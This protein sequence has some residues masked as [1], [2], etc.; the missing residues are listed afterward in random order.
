MQMCGFDI[1]DMIAMRR[2]NFD[3]KLPRLRIMGEWLAA[4]P[5]SK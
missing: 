5:T 1:V 3:S 4:K 2:Q